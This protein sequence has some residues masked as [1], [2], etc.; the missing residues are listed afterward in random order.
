MCFQ[1]KHAKTN[2]IVEFIQSLHLVQI[3][4]IIF[5]FIWIDSIFREKS[6][7][8]YLESASLESSHLQ[9]H[10]H[11]IYLTEYTT[12]QKKLVLLVSGLY[13]Q[14]Y[15]PYMEKVYLDLYK[16][17]QVREKYMFMIYEDRGKSNFRIAD[18]ISQYLEKVVGKYNLDELVIF[19]F[20]AGGIVASHIM[21]RM[22]HVAIEKKIITY[23]CPFNI[24]NMLLSQYNHYSRLDI[25]FYMIVRIFYETNKWEIY[26]DG[27]KQYLWRLGDKPAVFDFIKKTYKINDE[28]M[29]HIGEFNLD[30]DDKTSIYF[31]NCLNDP[32]FKKCFRDS[33]IEKA[34]EKKQR[35]E[36]YE[37]P[38][39]GHCS[40]MAFSNAYVSEVESILVD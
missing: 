18:D 27:A 10:S 20:S 6:I 33:I 30:Q 23:D 31:I 25:Y 3:I 9:T 15:N 17:K 28:E 29:V 7:P 35:I 40:D 37:K 39:I 5:H 26:L 36:L 13:Y 4:S 16:N 19:G 32:V 24:C 1:S 11:K 22:K 21:S 2:Y 8:L 14:Q 38:C 34:R 12:T